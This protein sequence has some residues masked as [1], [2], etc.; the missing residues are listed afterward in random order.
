MRTLTSFFLFNKALFV[1]I[2]LGKKISN[3]H[4]IKNILLLIILKFFSKIIGHI[5]ILI[6]LLVI[7]F[8]WNNNKFI[9]IFSYHYS[10]YISFIKSR[11]KSFI[12]LF[13]FFVKKIESFILQLNNN[14]KPLFFDSI[15]SSVCFF[16]AF[17][18]QF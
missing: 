12:I 5:F 6:N 13:S 3:Q 9:Y 2:L 15:F 18:W 16:F 14:L 7:W 11:F 1:T 17:F 10:E 4:Y 8:I